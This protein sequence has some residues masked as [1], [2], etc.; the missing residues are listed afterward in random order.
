MEDVIRKVKCFRCGYE[1][2][3]RKVTQPAHCPNR[4]CNSPYWNKPRVRGDNVEVNTA[5]TVVDEIK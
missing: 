2:F 3:P 1:W 5:M 4:K